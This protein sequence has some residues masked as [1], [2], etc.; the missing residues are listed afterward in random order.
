M[1]PLS[2]FA[3]IHIYAT[4]LVTIFSQRLVIYFMHIIL[5]QWVSFEGR[6]GGVGA[7]GDVV[8]AA[9]EEEIKVLEAVAEVKI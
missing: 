8:L 1:L 7:D 9:L 3:L 5:T 4:S 6:G 2:V